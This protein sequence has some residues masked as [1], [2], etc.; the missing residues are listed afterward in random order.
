MTNEILEDSF[1]QHVNGTM[2][3]FAIAM[4]I[5]VLI[6][7]FLLYKSVD[8]T[9]RAHH[10]K[11]IFT[12]LTLAIYFLFSYFTILSATGE[13]IICGE[14][15]Y[16]IAFYATIIPFIFIYS[17]GIFLISIF[18]GWVRCFSN[19]FGSSILSLGL[20]STIINKLNEPQGPSSDSSSR[21]RQLYSNDPKI[22]LNEI[23]FDS[24]GN[25]SSNVINAYKELG[26]TIENEND[27]DEI[28][29]MFKQYI[30]CKDSIGE[31][32]WHFLLGIISILSSYNIILAENCNTFTVTKDNFKKKL[33]EKFQKN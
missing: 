17:I 18:P 15:K 1:K 33:N 20:Q 29:N 11:I 2:T 6:K 26:I 7:T 5:F 19:T 14:Y 32:I 31:G 4:P 12:F 21:I 27:N 9:K 24:N 16:K 23:E 30:Y 25:L 28:K 13:E 22:L 10:L 3:V 8:E